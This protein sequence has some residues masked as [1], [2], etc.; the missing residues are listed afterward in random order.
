[1]EFTNEF[2]NKIEKRIIDLTTDIN[3]LEQ[4]DKLSELEKL[5][6]IYNNMNNIIVQR[7]QLEKFEE[8]QDMM[9]DVDISKYLDKFLGK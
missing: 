7:Q 9:K 5:M 1:M 2:I 3:I 4:E 8:L 6:S